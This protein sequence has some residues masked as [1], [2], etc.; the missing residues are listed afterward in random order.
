MQKLK[1]LLP[2]LTALILLGSLSS[3][4]EKLYDQ[5]EGDWDVTSYVIDDEENIGGDITTFTMEFDDYDADA[6]EGEFTWKIVY[7]D[8][9]IESE[10]GVY[11]VDLDDDTVTL[12]FESLG[13]TVEFDLEIN[14]DNLEM[15][16][17]LLGSDA[18]IEAERD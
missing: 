11:E 2:A 5:L 17:N 10:S 18:T 13:L 12:T 3:C 14:G 16:G 8:G 7:D 4:K 15:S 9:M 1:S 6:E